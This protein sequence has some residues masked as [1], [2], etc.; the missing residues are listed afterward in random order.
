MNSIDSIIFDVDGTLWDSTEI[1]SRAWNDA[2][3]QETKLSIT[4]TPDKLKSLFG[5]TLPDIAEIIFPQYSK[6]QQLEL[7]ELCCEKE[8]EYIKKYPPTTYPGLEDTLRHLSSAYPLFIVSNCEA[9]YI[10]AFLEVTGLSSYFKDHLCPGDTGNAKASNIKEIINRNNL[11]APV[12][13]GDTSGDY[14][15]T[16]EAGIPFVFAS[17]G[18]GEVKEANKTIT[19]LSD[20]VT[21]FVR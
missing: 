1:V 10:E 4:F 12:Y 13:V 14:H 21:M 18:F 3:T 2:I 19:Q 20:L 7:I 11:K 5:R 16:L 15:A 8:H 9:G 6:K 17:Y